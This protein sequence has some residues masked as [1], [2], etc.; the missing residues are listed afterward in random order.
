MLCHHLFLS[1]AQNKT[2]PASNNKTD[3]NA[4]VFQSSQL[5]TY[6]RFNIFTFAKKNETKA[7]QYKMEGK[8]ICPVA[9]TSAL[10]NLSASG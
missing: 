2:I 3:N 1:P 7:P 9:S 10:L 5:I 4:L 6:R 8:G